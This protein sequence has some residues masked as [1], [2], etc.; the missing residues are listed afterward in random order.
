[1]PENQSQPNISGN[2]ANPGGEPRVIPQP[3]APAPDRPSDTEAAHNPEEGGAVRDPRADT[4][5]SADQN[6]GSLDGHPAKDPRG[7]AQAGERLGD[8]GNRLGS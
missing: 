6:Y 8:R 2:P 3:D 1:M 7:D 5:D 4:A